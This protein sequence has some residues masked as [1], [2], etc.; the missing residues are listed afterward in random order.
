MNWLNFYL[1]I[2][3]FFSSFCLKSQELSGCNRLKAYAATESK[4]Q[5]LAEESIKASISIV[6]QEAVKKIEDAAIEY[7]VS[8]L[9]LAG[10]D[11]TEEGIAEWYANMTNM[12]KLAFDVI[13]K[14]DFM[15]DA[16]AAKRMAATIVNGIVASWLTK[17]FGTTLHEK[18]HNDAQKNA[19]ASETWYE[20]DFGK[21]HSEKLKLGQLFM[22]LFSSNTRAGA[23]AIFPNGISAKQKAGI[24]GSGVNANTSFAEGIE[25]NAVKSG[26]VHSTDAIHY[27]YNKLYLASYA[28]KDQSLVGSDPRNFV[29][30]LSKQGYVDESQIDSTVTKIGKYALLSAVMSGRSWDMVRSNIEYL[31]EGRTT[32]ETSHIDT[33]LGKVTLP[34]FNTYLNTE[35]V[36]IKA[37]TSLR[38]DDRRIYTVG[39]EKS[40]IGKNTTEV[41]VGTIVPISERLIVEVNGRHNNEGGWGLGTRLS[42]SVGD[43]WFVNGGFDY[44]QNTL[45]GDRLHKDYEDRE[46]ARVYLGMGYKF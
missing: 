17:A 13:N 2:L 21:G 27:M 23:V 6:E 7:K 1:C 34:D 4:F 29:E 10:K 16:G 45:F 39:I 9:A 20:L 35:S 40:V 12:N 36:S 30:A 37:D 26:Q 33:P 42:F 38:T 28:E 25:K 46:N 24:S 31:T 15:K 18:A 44:D 14:M 5:K 41:S 11:I 19:G 22:N 43:G 32:V 3:L 8:T